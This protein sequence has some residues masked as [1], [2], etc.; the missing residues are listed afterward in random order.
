MSGAVQVAIFFT[1]FDVA[2]Y[3]HDMADF[4]YYNA[5][6]IHYGDVVMDLLEYPTDWIS[7][8]AGLLASVP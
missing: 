8:L 6:G 7:L 1:F 2:A 3:F 4:R 5:L